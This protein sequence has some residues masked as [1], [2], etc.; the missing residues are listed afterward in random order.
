MARRREF[1]RGARVIAQRR[2]TSWFQFA[3]VRT[4]LTDLSGTLI[5]TLNAAALALR[6]FTIVR[7][8]FLVS[9]QS[10]QV[11]ATEDQV[12]AMGL[13]VVSD[14][15]TAVGITAIPT[16]IANMESDLWFVHQLLYSQFTFISGVGIQDG[17]LQQY[18][19]DSK[20]MRKV[21]IGQ[22]VV[23]VGERSVAGGGIDVVIG[24]RMLIK[25]N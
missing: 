4:V 6:P 11:G 7:T 24:G 18:E 3:P 8:R 15:A 13:A 2:L 9:I 12:G 1:A 17:G 10:D 21:D 19:I 5:F 14:Q 25:V 22:D 23:V 16:P 20:A